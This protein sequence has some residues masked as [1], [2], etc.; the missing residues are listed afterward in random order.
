MAIYNNN[1]ESFNSNSPFLYS[2]ITDDFISDSFDLETV[3]IGAI[4]CTTPLYNE[5]IERFGSY[6]NAKVIYL[7]PMI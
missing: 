6:E 1:I 4:V 2:E 3:D 5:L 7:S